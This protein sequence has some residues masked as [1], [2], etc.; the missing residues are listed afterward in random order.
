MLECVACE[1]EDR[2]LVRF[3]HA[4]R[5]WLALVHGLDEPVCDEFEEKKPYWSR[6]E[7]RKYR[8]KRGVA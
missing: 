1:K 5:C 8:R 2:C 7:W 4:R 6:L 3:K